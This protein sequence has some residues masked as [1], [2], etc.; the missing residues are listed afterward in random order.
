MAETNELSYVI[1]EIQRWQREYK[2]A[3]RRLAGSMTAFRAS[4]AVNV[5][6]GYLSK[7]TVW[8]NA[9]NG[10]TL[11][12]TLLTDLSGANLG[13]LYFQPITDG[14][15]YGWRITNGL[16][17]AVNFTATALANQEVTLSAE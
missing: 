5:P 10:D 7:R 15:R 4:T 14:T 1:A 6:A 16:D 17:G 11:V 2:S 3:Q 13:Q 8:I 9:K 12:A